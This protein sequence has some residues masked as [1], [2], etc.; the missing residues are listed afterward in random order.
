MMQ[1]GPTEEKKVPTTDDEVRTACTGISAEEERR[2]WE[3]GSIQVPI[4]C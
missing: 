4:I 3:L 1:E 2:M